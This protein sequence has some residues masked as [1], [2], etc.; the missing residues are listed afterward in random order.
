MHCHPDVDERIKSFDKW[1]VVDVSQD[2][3]ELLK[4]IKSVLHKHE[5]V[6]QG[7]MA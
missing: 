6:K 7:T 2:V 4:L 1:T 3:V 5:K